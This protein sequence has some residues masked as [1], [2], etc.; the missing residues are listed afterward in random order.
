MMTL[1]MYTIRDFLTHTNNSVNSEYVS[2]FQ[3]EVKEDSLTFFLKH[4]QPKLDST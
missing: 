4:D 2:K 3:N 1:N